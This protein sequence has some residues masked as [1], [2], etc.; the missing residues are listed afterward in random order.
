MAW[1]PSWTLTPG[2]SAFSSGT[3]ESGIITA[4]HWVSEVSK[5][6]SR[7]KLC[8]SEFG[9]L[10]AP[11]IY[12]FFFGGWVGERKFQ[13]TLNSHTSRWHNQRVLRQEPRGRSWSRGQGGIC[14]P[15]CSLSGLVGFL[16]HPEPTA[17]GRNHLHQSLIKTMHY[18]L[19]YLPV[20]Q[21]RV[22]SWESLFPNDSN[23]GRVDLKLARRE[24][25]AV[26]LAGLPHHRCE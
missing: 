15:A 25:C 24:G 14:L 11:D 8:S 12:L 4:S 26:C 5:R 3:W 1:N 21:R 20:L 10:L 9:S 13:F 7:W 23:L 16:W 17:E 6:G 2:A 22:L 19:V 18:R